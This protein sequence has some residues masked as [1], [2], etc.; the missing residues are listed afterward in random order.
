MGAERRLCAQGLR[1]GLAPAYGTDSPIMGNGRWSPCSRVEHVGVNRF[2]ATPVH[3]NGVCC[4]EVD[5]DRAPGVTACP[6]RRCR[7]RG[8]ALCPG[9]VRSLCPGVAGLAVNRLDR[10]GHDLPANGSQPAGLA[11][12]HPGAR[13]RCQQQRADP[14]PVAPAAGPPSST[15][16]PAAMAAA[17]RPATS[18]PRAGGSRRHRSVRVRAPSGTAPRRD[19][20]PARCLRRPRWTGKHHRKACS[21]RKAGETRD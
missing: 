4:P 9:H 7:V 11:S 15:A 3:V 19:P 8:C 13:P 18:H 12:T 17:N 14:G 16:D 2:A 10:C 5:Q 1:M 21:P 6:C 20:S